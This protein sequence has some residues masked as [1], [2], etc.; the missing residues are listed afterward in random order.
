MSIDIR[1]KKGGFGG[2][3]LK[4][5]IFIFL[6]LCVAIGVFFALKKYFKIGESGVSMSKGV[7]ITDQLDMPQPGEQIAAIYVK[8]YGNG[9]PIKCR[10]FE[11]AAPKAV[12]NFVELAKAGKYNGVEFDRVIPDFMIQGGGDSQSIF[13]KPFG[14]EINPSL[15]H[16]N[17]AMGV[18]RTSSLE[19]GQ[20]CQF[21]IVCSD[22]GRRANFDDLESDMQGGFGVDDESNRMI[23]KNFG[24]IHFDGEVRNKFREVGGYPYLDLRYTI[25]GQV[26]DGMEIVSQIAECPKQT[27]V[28]FEDPKPDPP[29]IIEKIEILQWQG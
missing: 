10:L 11:K 19:D 24:G 16:Y 2:R 14:V 29:V 22:D 6:V 5:A 26:F 1:I 18:A 23:E 3:K 20:T 25:F 9:Q 4:T 28:L 15:H 8:D 12:K 7:V 17:G 27:D 21:Y 13:G